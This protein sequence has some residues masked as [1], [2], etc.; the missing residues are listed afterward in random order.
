MKHDLINL[1]SDIGISRILAKTEKYTSAELEKIKSFITKENINEVDD[2]GLTPLFWAV[3]LAY[4]FE[5][6][7][8]LLEKGA[9]LE[10]LDKK[11]ESILFRQPRD[12]TEYLEFLYAMGMNLNH[13]NK[14]GQ[15][16]LH[17]RVKEGDIEAVSFLIQKKVKTDLEDSEGCIPLELAEAYEY[18]DIVKLLVRPKKKE[19]KQ[20]VKVV[21]I[22]KIVDPKIEQEAAKIEKL[23]KGSKE[24]IKKVLTYSVVLTAMK[25]IF[26]K[27]FETRIDFYSKLFYYYSRDNPLT[28]ILIVKSIR[29]ILVKKEI[30]FAESVVAGLVFG[31]KPFESYIP[32]FHRKLLREELSKDFWKKHV[33][34]HSF[35]I[36]DI[37][38]KDGESFYELKKMG[39]LSDKAYTLVKFKLAGATDCAKKY[40]SD[41]Q[42]FE[43]KSLIEFLI[44]G[45]MKLVTKVLR[46]DLVVWGQ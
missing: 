10:H 28:S 43:K 2:A 25:K 22:E 23:L 34:E 9:K 30:G 8:L 40:S 44:K 19:A 13:A 15:T 5:F 24:D 46:P 42:K 12:G 36:G 39:G 1:M 26:G 45:K 37:W 29:D 27:E 3:A 31:F 11:G 7:D 21:K 38:T 35:K 16:V 6:I 41:E 18:H 20:V 14:E 33:E 32:Q 17:Q 4:P